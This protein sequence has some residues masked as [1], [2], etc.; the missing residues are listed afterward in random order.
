[1]YSDHSID[2]LGSYIAAVY[3]AEIFER[4]ITLDKKMKGPDH[5]CSDEFL[6]FSYYI[7]RIKSI[8]LAIGN[9]IKEIKRSEINMKMISRKSAYF[10]KD[11]TKDSLISIED[12]IF[13]RPGFDGLN[14]YEVF[15]LIF[16]KN[17]YKK[18]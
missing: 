10:Q 6:E 5:H 14:E 9:G 1:M 15:E 3:G 2:G 7:N 4:H 18:L 16:N 13:Q 11:V 17:T 8:K 12:F